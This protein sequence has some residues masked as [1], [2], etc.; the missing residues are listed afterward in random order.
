MHLSILRA[1]NPD[2]L[3]EMLE[4]A[5]LFEQ[6]SKLIYTADVLYN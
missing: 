1:F 3:V 4:A 2:I 5:H 6:W